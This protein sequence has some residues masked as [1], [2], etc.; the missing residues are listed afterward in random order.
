MRD[1]ERGAALHGGFQ[2]GLH[3]A[4]TFCVERAGGFVQQQERRIFEHGACN[5]DAL[6]LATRQ[7]HA[8][9]AQIRVV[10]LGQG[11]D[12]VVCIGGP[13]SGLDLVVA[14][15][16]AAIADVFKGA[17][18]EHGAVLRNDANAV[19]QCLQAGLTHWHAIDQNL[20]MQHVV[21]AQQQM[22][23]GAF[24]RAAGAHQGDGLARAHLQV[25]V[26]Q[27]GVQRA[28]WVVEFHAG[29]LHAGARLYGWQSARCLRVD[30]G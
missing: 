17:G 10:A 8:A 29:K 3:P 18:R 22:K 14:G 4:F 26:A 2:G 24:A 16:R 28:R 19:A 7:A 5:A 20:T 9:F 6:T 30:H 1:D 13:G 11:A 21:R 23:N 27:S 15:V 12:E 25:K